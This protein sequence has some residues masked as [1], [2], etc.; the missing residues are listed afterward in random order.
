MHGVTATW[1]VK[2]TNPGR[3][4]ARANGDVGDGAGLEW[5]Y[6]LRGPLAPAA[7]LQL[8]ESSGD[9]TALQMGPSHVG[10]YDARLAPSRRFS[11][12]AGR[13]DDTMSWHYGWDQAL[14]TRG[15]SFRDKPGPFQIQAHGAGNLRC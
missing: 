2:M 11:A 10:S 4:R 3:S 8:K 1:S 9:G 6:L 7:W 5:V 14:T 13:R 15:H 12:V